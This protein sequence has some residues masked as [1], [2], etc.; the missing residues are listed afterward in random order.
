MELRGYVE[1]NKHS[2]DT[3]AVTVL[4]NGNRRDVSVVLSEAPTP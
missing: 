2:G 4:R 1:N 3:V